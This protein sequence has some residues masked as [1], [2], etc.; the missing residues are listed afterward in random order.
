MKQSEPIC[1]TG[2]WL[3]RRLP[4]AGA[5]IVRSPH[6]KERFRWPRRW[7]ARCSIGVASVR[8]NRTPISYSAGL[9]ERHTTVLARRYA[10]EDDSSCRHTGGITKHIGWHFFRRSFA[11]MLQANGVSVKATQDMLR[12]ANGRLTLEL[13]AQSVPEDRREAQ[14]GILRTVTAS[15]PKRSLI[16]F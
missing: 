5:R 1:R 8:T 13:Y 9:R 2:G 4:G 16:N 15:V 10:A 14:A 3:K 12:H 6:S 11:T 7:E